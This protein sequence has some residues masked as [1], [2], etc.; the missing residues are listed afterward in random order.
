MEQPIEKYYTYADIFSWG[1]DVRAQIICGD[2]YMMAP[3]L[4]IHQEVSGELFGQIRDFL[5]DKP[6]KVYS[7]PFGVRPFEKDGD[8]PDDVD[9]VVEPD[10]TVVCDH[11]KLDK[12]GCKGAPD[13]IIE[14]LSPSTARLDNFV[15]LNLYQRAK[16]REYWVV[17]PL[18]ATVN[19]YLPDETERLVVSE[20]YTRKDVAKV[21]VLPGCEIDLSKVFPKEED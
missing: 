12:Y 3:P 7:A 20:V 5:K 14:I 11:S 10:I 13:F 17:D 21:T 8:T 16:V 2:L 1:E 18:N 4:R 9:T 19:V 6:C 15:K